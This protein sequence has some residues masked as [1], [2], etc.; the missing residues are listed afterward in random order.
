MLR[1]SN[2]TGVRINFLIRAKSGSRNSCHSVI[3]ASATPK[4]KGFDESMSVDY[5]GKRSHGGMLMPVAEY[6]QLNLAV[7][8][9][10]CLKDQGEQ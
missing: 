3:T 1:P 9:E 8:V 4:M 7:S 2:T 5:A 10:W 6:K